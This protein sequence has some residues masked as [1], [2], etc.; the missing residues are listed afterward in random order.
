MKMLTNFWRVLQLGQSVANPAA[1]K[2]GQITANA[3]V[4]FLYAGVNLAASFGYDLPATKE[5][6]DAIGL[7]LFALVNVLLTVTTSKTV[8]LPP[9]VR[10]D[11]ETPSSSDG[12]TPSRWD[13]PETDL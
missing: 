4:A 8:G 7:G 12:R 2:A 3:V 10:P 13:D 11:P 9:R 6:L 1:W 5:Q